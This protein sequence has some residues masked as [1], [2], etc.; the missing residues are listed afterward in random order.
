MNVETTAK[1]KPSCFVVMPFG[2]DA[3]E[4]KWFSGWYEVVLSPAIHAA[5]YIPVLSAGEEQPGAINDEIRAH[6]AYDPMVLVDLGG[7]EQEDEPNPNVMYELGIRHALGLPLVIMAWEGQRLPFDVSNQRVI[8]HSRDFLD[9]EIN[10]KKI[11]AF[12]QAASEGK[13]YRPMDS[14]GR[15]AT[16]AAASNTLGEDA[17]LSALVQ[18]VKELRNSLNSVAQSP[19]ARIQWESTLYVKTLLKTKQLRSDLYNFFVTL[20]GTPSE[21]SK[22]IKARVSVDFSAEAENWTEVEWRQYI[23]QRYAELPKKAHLGS[24]AGAVAAAAP[25]LRTRTFGVTEE[26]LERVKNTLPPQ[27]WPTGTHKQ[28]TEALGISKSLYDKA[29]VELIKRRVVY[30]QIDGILL[31]TN[32]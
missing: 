27:P 17:I 16:I 12:I 23:E 24:E 20:G 19:R 28:V 7:F 8:M 31:D 4:R 13:Y 30:Q 25:A 2:R 3:D 21:W 14:V 26:L 15:M 9:I 29:I 1:E 18:E 10:K 22:V 32:A 11:V 6:L 5:G